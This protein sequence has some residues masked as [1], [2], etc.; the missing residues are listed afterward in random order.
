M[1]IATVMAIFGV[2]A[3]V[4]RPFPDETPVATTAAWV[5]APAEG[6]PYGTDLRKI[7]GRRVLALPRDAALPTL[8]RGSLIAAPEQADGEM[9]TWRIDEHL[10]PSDID[11]WRVWVT[12]TR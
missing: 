8:P 2:S 11:E 5:P 10:A 6:Q 4:T 12:Q 7:D 9:L 3:T 1:P